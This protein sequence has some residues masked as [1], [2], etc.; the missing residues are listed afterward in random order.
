M[1]YLTAKYLDSIYKIERVC[2]CSAELVSLTYII[3]LKMQK[4][5]HKIIF[6]TLHKK[7]KTFLSIIKS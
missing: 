1:E 5:I 4:K 2:I 3:S 7:R 6:I